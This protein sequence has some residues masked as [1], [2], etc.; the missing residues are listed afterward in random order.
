MWWIRVLKVHREPQ[1]CYPWRKRHTERPHH[2][3]TTSCSPRSIGSSEFLGP[4]AMRVVLNDSMCELKITHGCAA[5]AAAAAAAASAI[6]GGGDVGATFVASSF[7]KWDALEEHHLS[8]HAVTELQEGDSSRR[9]VGNHI[10]KA[11]WLKE[12][13]KLKASKLQRSILAV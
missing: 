9:I 10:A 11:S 5:A 8:K 6:N 7:L 3:Q 2:H 12:T 13:V 1:G 4:I